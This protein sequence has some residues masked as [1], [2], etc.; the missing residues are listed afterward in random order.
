MKT[1]KNFSSHLLA[2]A[3][4]AGFLFLLPGC[5]KEEPAPVQPYQELFWVTNKGSQMPVLMTGN[6]GSASI[7]LFIHGGPGSS[8]IE[9]AGIYSGNSPAN[10]TDNF[11]LASW[12]QRYAGYSI[13]PDP[14]D[15]STVNVDKYAED[16]AM[17]IKH[18]FI[19]HYPQVL[20]N[21]IV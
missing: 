10:L 12:D 20:W 8:S 5:K 16:C 6:K 15:W 2:L 9:I 18:L 11:L 3:L 7:V 14:V 13:N 17:A 1:N 4:F 19:S 21:L